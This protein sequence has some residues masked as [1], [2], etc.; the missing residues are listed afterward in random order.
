[1]LEQVI[2][3]G[4]KAVSLVASDVLDA[5]IHLQAND[6]DENNY[7]TGS[8]M[9]TYA[10]IATN[11]SRAKLHSMRQITCRSTDKLQAN[12]LADAIATDFDMIRGT[13]YNYSWIVG[14]L[15]IYDSVEKMHGTALT[16]SIVSRKF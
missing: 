16:L 6:E 10:E 13:D 1:M 2:Y 8:P 11:Y 3:D 4:I 12:A 15:P 14:R 5:N 7:T 9:I